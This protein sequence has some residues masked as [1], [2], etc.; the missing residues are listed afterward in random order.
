MRAVVFEVDVDGVPD[1][2]NDPVV[3]TV[4]VDIFNAVS[5]PAPSSTTCSVADASED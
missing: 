5:L 1:I 3:S 2:F 4:S